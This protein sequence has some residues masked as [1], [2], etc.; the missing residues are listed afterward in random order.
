[1]DQPVDS[2]TPVQF[3][4]IRIQRML[5]EL[6]GSEKQ[7]SWAKRIR[8]ERMSR[9]GKSD[10]IIFSRV[11]HALE[12]E[13]SAAWW[14]TYREKEIGEV[15]K[16]IQGGGESSGK[17]TV[18]PKAS[19]IPSSSTSKTYVATGDDGGIT[20]YVGELRDVVTGKAVVDPE[21]PF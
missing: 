9:W 14:I 3:T 10:P 5:A 12:K 19:P 18:K 4:A 13:T 17:A 7:I 1:M 21:C 15:L 2:V 6:Q 8:T 11:E 16:Y 20:R